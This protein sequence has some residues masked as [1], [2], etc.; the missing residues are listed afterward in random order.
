MKTQEVA[1]PINSTTQAI[2]H[3]TTVK[4]SSTAMVPVAGLMGMA[5]DS[6]GFGKTLE[7]A[8]SSEWTG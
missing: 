3:S 4:S 2:Q 6:P 8:M 1:T 7:N 5:L